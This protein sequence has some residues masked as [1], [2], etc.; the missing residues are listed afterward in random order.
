[1]GHD[2]TYKFPDL[3]LEFIR[4]ICSNDIKGEIREVL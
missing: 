2:R 4:S 3:V 1:M